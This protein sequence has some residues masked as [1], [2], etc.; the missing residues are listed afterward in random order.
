MCER[1]RERE[2]ERGSK[3]LSQLVDLYRRSRLV[4]EIKAVDNDDFLPLWELVVCR[5]RRAVLAARGRGLC[6]IKSPVSLR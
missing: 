5:A 2:E 6:G 3:C 4:V 1:E